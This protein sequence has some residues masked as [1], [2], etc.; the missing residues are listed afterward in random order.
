MPEIKQSIEIHAPVSEVFAFVDRPENLPEIW[1]SMLE[2]GNVTE[3]ANGGHDFDWVYKMAGMKFRGRS[4]SIE[5]ER[6][7]RIAT[8]SE[9]GIPSTF[10]W[11]FEA[12]DDTTVFTQEIEYEIPHTLL[13]R[14]AAPFIHKLNEREGRLVMENL[15]AR[16]EHAAAHAQPEAHPQP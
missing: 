14:I 6:D 1:P 4:K 15:K 7:R 5:F 8:R 3:S 9:T 12:R 11:T 13:A 2:V 10:H 16:V